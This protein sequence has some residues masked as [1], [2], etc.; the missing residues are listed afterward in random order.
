MGVFGGV[1]LV[2]VLTLG[3]CLAALY[4]LDKD[5]GGIDR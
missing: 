5:A 3:A 2:S 4:F 1:L